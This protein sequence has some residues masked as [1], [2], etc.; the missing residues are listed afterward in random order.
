MTPVAVDSSVVMKWC[1]AEVLTAEAVRLRDSGWPLHAPA[2]L[3]VEAANTVWKKIRLKVMTREEGDF[4]LSQ[5]PLL[6]RARFADEMLMRV[7]WYKNRH[8]LV[9]L[10]GADHAGKGTSRRRPSSATAKCPSQAC[11]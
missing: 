1:V 11:P 10:T 7:A 8:D 2:L 6:P 3:D 9:T 5:L 4:I